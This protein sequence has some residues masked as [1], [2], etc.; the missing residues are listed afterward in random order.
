MINI[1]KW[2]RVASKYLVR[3]KWATLRVDEVK[4]PDGIIKNDYYV[5][6]YT[7]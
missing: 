7:K 4:L 1:E 5:L 3:E 6:E 2:Q